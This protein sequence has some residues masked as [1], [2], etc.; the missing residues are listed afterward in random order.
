MDGR[1]AL[2]AAYGR[3]PKKRRCAKYE[4]R[5]HCFMNQEH[6]FCIALAVFTA[7]FIGAAAN[8]DQPTDTTQLIQPSFDR[9][10]PTT[11]P[12]AQPNYAKLKTANS[13]QL[14]Q[15]GFERLI[16]T[17]YPLIVPDAARLKATTYDV[18]I[19]KANQP[20]PESKAVHV[21]AHS[22]M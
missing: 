21:T 4:Q 11:Y 20:H 22:G 1:E 14:I 8:A 18:T 12:L 10:I 15:P 3:S 9:L 6:I 17:T 5:G 7:A 13:S 16:P 2:V 19:P